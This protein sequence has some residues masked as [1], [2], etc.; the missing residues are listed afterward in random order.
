[1]CMFV[2]LER[3][4]T[5]VTAVLPHTGISVWRDAQR[6]HKFSF[7]E[8]WEKNGQERH[9]ELHAGSVSPL[10]VE[11]SFGKTQH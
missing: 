6:K 7:Q 10:G 5:T 2:H 1:M 3:V 8:K 11:T 9:L 4:I